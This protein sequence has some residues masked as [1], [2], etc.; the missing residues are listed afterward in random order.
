LRLALFLHIYQPPTQFPEVTKEITE[1]S[2]LKIIEILKKNPQAK[3]TLNICGSLAAQLQNADCHGLITDLHGLA[4]EGRVELTGSAAY[5][6]LLPK[7][8][9]NEI[10]RQIELNEKI[11]KGVF[12]NTCQPSGFFPPEMAYQR[13]VG[14]IVEK[15]GYKWLLLDESAFPR[16]SGFR[17]NDRLYDL[18]GTSLKVFFRERETSLAIAFAKVASVSDFKKIFLNRI[19]PQSFIILAMDGETF[20][21]HQI[22]QLNFLDGFFACFKSGLVTISELLTMFDRVETVEP[23]TST[24]GATIEDSELG[25]VFPRWDNPKNPI[26]RWQWKLFRLALKFSNCQ[27]RVRNLLDKAVHSDQ[28]F[29]AAHDPC[30][31]PEM[32]ER[33]A[34]MLR[35]VVLDIGD[36]SVGDKKKAE[37]LY[38]KII[39][40]GKKMYGEEIV[41]C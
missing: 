20:G 11:N 24:W 29:W 7:L 6:P 36:A 2:Y 9:D 35:D 16:R 12:G 8:P 40:T 41:A 19:A 21:H 26:H 22:Y 1:T 39:E 13:R 33:G 34:R 37:M 15:L 3:I 17:Y 25:R 38:E 31:H 27:G 4:R 30:W 23:L 18:E 14:E 32:I 5:H 10:I 28:F